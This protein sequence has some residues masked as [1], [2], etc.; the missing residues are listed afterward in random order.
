MS[1]MQHDAA[2]QNESRPAGQ[3]G[4]SR[5]TSFAVAAVLGIIAV[6]IQA[7]LCGAFERL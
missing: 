4:F 7:L 6:F 1:A 2:N 3:P 5:R